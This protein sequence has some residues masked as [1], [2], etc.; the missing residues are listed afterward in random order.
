MSKKVIW[1]VVISV[2]G[3]LILATG[4]YAGVRYY[5]EKQSEKKADE[6]KTSTTASDSTTSATSDSGA[7]SE[8]KNPGNTNPEWLT[9]SNFLTSYMI[10]YPK[11]AKIEDMGSPK[12][13][14]ISDSACVKISTDTYY[15][16]VGKV[17]DQPADCFR[18][19]VAEDWRTGP[20]ETV[21]P[22]G[23]SYTVTGMHNEAA[24][25]GYYNDFFLVNLIDGTNKIEYGIS[26]NEKYGQGTKVGAKE[27]VHQIVATY[28][29]AE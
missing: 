25:A 5:K 21:T 26:V 14:K 2:L 3:A 7:T 27:L 17:T 9:Y 1:I 19:G 12:A 22:A 11:E 18:T 23:A 8:R 6:A 20:T 10:S 28:N 15:V 24:S 16:L 4:I 13:T 29:P